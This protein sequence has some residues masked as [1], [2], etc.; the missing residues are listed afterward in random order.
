MIVTDNAQKEIRVKSVAC[1]W[2]HTVAVAGAD[3]D[4]YTWGRCVHGQLGHGDT[5]RRAAPTKEENL[6]LLRQGIA[7]LAKRARVENDMQVPSQSNK[8]KKAHNDFE[9][10]Q[11][12]AVPEG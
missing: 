5:T 10:K 1:G 8:H 11:D 6:A 4:V 3:E 7:P 12:A 9:K 2:R